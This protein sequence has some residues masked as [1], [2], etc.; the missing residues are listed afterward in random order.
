M[1]YD[2]ILRMVVT[3]ISQYFRLI[4]LP[5]ASFGLIGAALSVIGVVSPR[6]AE[7]MVE[8]FSPAQN[9]LWLAGLTLVSLLG[10]TGFFPYLG[11]V[12]V[13]V[14]FFLMMLVSFF[15]SHYLNRIT[16]SHRRATVLSFKGMAF[17]LAYGLIGI[18]FALLVGQ[19]RHQGAAVEHPKGAELS[20][21]D[22]AF[23][24]AIFWLPWYSLFILGVI[25]LY[26]FFRLRGSEQIRQ[27]G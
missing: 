26:C 20:L 25:I 9:T 21:A 5:E 18:L 27:K 17:N 1:G 8:I 2:H 4:N 11:L 24:G 23:K 12:P 10:L 7:K 3:L 13:A 19:L 15:S 16:P 22:E 14:I 6:I